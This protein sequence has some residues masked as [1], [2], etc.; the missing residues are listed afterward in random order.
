LL[1]DR[2]LGLL[3]GSRRSLIGLGGPPTRASRAALARGS[4]GFGF[5]GW[6]RR[7]GR[8]R[9]VETFESFYFG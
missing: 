1:G 4:F 3:G 6:F 7:G 2:L 9:D 8:D 5:F